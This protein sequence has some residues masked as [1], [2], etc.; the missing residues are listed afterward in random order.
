MKPQVAIHVNVACLLPSAEPARALRAKILL[1]KPG[2]RGHTFRIEHVADGRYVQGD[3]DL[4]TFFEHLSFVLWDMT[5][6]PLTGNDT[7]DEFISVFAGT[8]LDATVSYRFRGEHREEVRTLPDLEDA[9]HVA[10]MGVLRNR[11]RQN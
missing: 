8:A 5:A 9:I 1:R 10:V 6:P 2:T 4:G 3:A 11:V 7:A